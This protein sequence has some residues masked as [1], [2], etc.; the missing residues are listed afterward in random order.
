M[1]IRF[2]HM[3]ACGVLFAA[4]LWVPTDGRE[5]RDE[6]GST[7]S[8]QP[9]AQTMRSTQGSL[10]E[11]SFEQTNATTDQVTIIFTNTP[12]KETAPAP[13]PVFGSDIVQ[14]FSFSGRDFPQGRVAFS[15]RVRDKSFLECRYIR[16]V[17]Q[18]SNRWFAS[19]I[20]LTV[21]GQR[22][23]DNVSMYPRRGER[24]GGIE[25]WNRATWPPTFWEADL[26]RFRPKSAS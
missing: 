9:Y 6:Q 23:L 21:D 20:T 24:K 17:N 12:V 2:L 3:P 26:Q 8:R 11:F 10:V 18:G 16:V 25:R 4:A 5:W 14:E 19:T 22:I 7:G 15:R 1:I 13:F